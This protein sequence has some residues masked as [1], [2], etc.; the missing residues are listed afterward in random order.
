MN[1]APGFN[2]E[3]VK[4]PVRIEMY[5]P[6]MFLGGWEWFSG[7]SLLNKPV[8]FVWLPNGTHLLVKPWE[9]MTSEQG[10][11]D[12]FRFWLQGYED[13][14]PEKK[15]QYVRWRH[16]RDLQDTEDKASAQTPARVSKPN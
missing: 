1:N 9:R 14:D 6:G 5:G 4:T 11:V 8:D 13:P 16:L 7:L 12:W 15:Q 10:N 3:K 2:L